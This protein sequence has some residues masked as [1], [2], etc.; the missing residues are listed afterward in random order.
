MTLIKNECYPYA[1]HHTSIGLSVGIKDDDRVKRPMNAFMVWSR[2][3]RRKM[4]QENPKMHNS[5]ISKRLG[6]EW[7][8]L[9]EQD[10]RP[11]I[12]EAKRLRA[13]HMKE[14]P[15]Y[16]YRPRR[17]TKT[18]LRKENVQKYQ[19]QQASNQFPQL[20]GLTG[21]NLTNG[22]SMHTN[23]FANLNGLNGLNGLNPNLTN[24]N[25]LFEHTNG[26]N[27]HH[28]QQSHQV[29]QQTQHQN[30]HQ[31][32][33]NHNQLVNSAVQQHN[34]VQNQ[35]NQLIT[36]HQLNNQNAHASVAQHQLTQHQLS[37]PNSHFTT[38]N[39]QH[40][41]AAVSQPYQQT[42]HSIHQTATQ[43]LTTPH[44][45]QLSQQVQQQQQLLNVNVTNG[46]PQQ[47]TTPNANNS[48][49]NI[50]QQ[51]NN[52]NNGTV[53]PTSASANNLLSHN[54]LRGAANAYP[55]VANLQNYSD[56]SPGWPSTALASYMAAYSASPK[57]DT[58]SNQQ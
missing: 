31:Q 17:K 34:S 30:T 48:A 27:Q 23:G 45:T 24:Y 2:G 56:Y 43:H 54:L 3:Q 49:Y 22:N 18:L 9:S 5:E 6:S 46:H 26:Y 47:S 14:H 44:Q 52:S 7:K 37:P 36:Q 28:Y 11:F 1:N 21:Q 50:L 15:D 29:L 51:A 57:S 33:S 41:A 39:H 12:D 13:V 55:Y 58:S 8:L 19:H 20:N 25:N 35:H 32:N 16:K 4:A 10:K 40:L 53:T 42:H 38:A